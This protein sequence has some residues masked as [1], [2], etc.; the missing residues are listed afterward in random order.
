[1]YDS[2]FIQHNITA[3]NVN[4]DAGNGSG[5]NLGSGAGQPLH[6]DL[7]YVS[8]YIML[9]EEFE[10]GGTFFEDQ[11]LP[12]VLSGNHD[13]VM[14]PLKPLGP[15]HTFAHY[16]KSRHAGAATYTGVCNILVIFLAAKAKR[17]ELSDSNRTWNTPCWERNA[18]LKATAC[19]YVQ[20]SPKRIN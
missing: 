19:T 8:V 18:R 13:N 4:N 6:R 3:A 5:D 1:V 16:S 10:G 9:N 14:H 17:A 11:L 12:F 20:C 2:L 15:R 7:G